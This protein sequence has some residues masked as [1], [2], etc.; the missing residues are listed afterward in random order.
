MAFLVDDHVNTV[1]IDM[2][3]RD[4]T[5]QFCNRFEDFQ[6]FDLSFSFLMKPKSSKDLNLSAFEWMDTEDFQMH[7]IDFKTSL[8]WTSKFVDLRKS[9]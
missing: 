3:T 7:P 9:L 2:Y 4:L 8:L 1:E 5:S 6:H